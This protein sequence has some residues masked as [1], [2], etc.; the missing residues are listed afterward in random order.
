M[1]Q[2]RF[3]FTVDDNIWVLGDLTRGQPKSLFA[4]PYLALYRRMHEKYGLK[5]QLNLFYEDGGFNLSMMTDRYRDEWAAN[6]DWLKLSFHSRADEPPKPYELSGYDEVYGDCADVHREILRF[7]GQDSLAKTTT[8]HYVRTTNE[9]VQALKDNGVE[10]LLGLYGTD[11]NPR[12]SYQNTAEE[13]A[14][15]RHGELV[16]RDGMTYGS[17]DLILNNCK[18]ADIKECLSS[19]VGRPTVKVMIHEQYFYPYFRGHQPDFEEKLDTAFAYLRE[20]GYVSAF[21][22]DCL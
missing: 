14:R 4:H 5:V 9:G 18:L 21:F 15:V 19:F 22:E 6:A 10:G 1:E 2:I 7:A 16:E 3:F 17:I 12:I 13:A 20:H 8:I 11:E